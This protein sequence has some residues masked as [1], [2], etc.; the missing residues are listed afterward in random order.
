[1]LKSLALST[2]AVAVLLPRTMV[3][4]QSCEVHTLPHDTIWGST[5]AGGAMH[6]DGD[7][8]SAG[9]TLDGLGDV[10]VWKVSKEGDLIW[11]KRFAALNKNVHLY[12]YEVAISANG[13]IIVMGDRQDNTP[14]DY[15]RNQ[16]AFVLSSTGEILWARIYMLSDQ[17][18]DQ[19]SFD[20]GHDINPTSTGWLLTLSKSDGIHAIDL[21][22]NGA[23]LSRTEYRPSADP[24]DCASG[25]VLVEQN[26][27]R[28]LTGS[29]QGKPFVMRIAS[30]GQVEW[31]FL[32]HFGEGHPVAVTKASNG[33]YLIAG[34]KRGSLYAEPDYDPFAMRISV[35]G[36]FQWAYDYNVATTASNIA[37]LPNGDIVMSC[38]RQLRAI[39]MSAAGTPISCISSTLPS[40]GGDLLGVSGDS[41]LFGN[42]LFE[43]FVTPGTPQV[44]IADSFNALTCGGLT[45]SALP[46]W[47][48]Y[49]TST[50]T[51]TLFIGTDSTRTW[52][53]ALGAPVEMDALD[54]EVY[55]SS[56]PARPGFEVGLFGTIRNGMMLPSGPIEVTMAL[57][58]VLSFVQAT[59]TPTSVVGNSVTWNLPPLYGM[60]SAH[61]VYVQAEVP[62]DVTLLGSELSN[63]LN[64]IQDS[65]EHSL[66]NNTV[67]F[68][69]IVTGSY[70]PNDKL[71]FPKD[72]YHIT[73]DSILDYT[74]RFQN[75]GT[76]TAFNI[77]VIDTLPPDVDVLTFEAGA[78]SHPY[79]YTL[80]G[81]GLLK[82]T[83]NNILLPDSNTNEPLSHGLVNFRIKP[84]QPIYLGQTISNEADIYFDFNPPVRT[85][86]AAVVVTDFMAVKPTAPTNELKLYPVPV[87]DVLTVEVPK[88]FLP[89]NAL[90]TANDGRTVWNSGVMNTK[91][92]L[93]IPVQKLAIG[94]YTLTLLSVHGERSQARFVKE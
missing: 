67:T 5:L 40:G 23:I 25:A 10:V 81:E 56:G 63:V 43:E 53:M 15:Q 14:F 85:P 61:G 9:L 74:I 66:A 31:A 72:F 92:R 41:L 44:T 42:Y 21:D 62:Q 60:Q 84:I 73:N 8:V 57:D 29:A 22:N 59:P 91:E 69:R 17:L 46:P 64:T 94:A 76:D 30:G 2:I 77:V 58:P 55:A 37:E 19:L 80:T 54:L 88:G 35:T 12:P 48:N 93:S 87:R 68:T 71:V 47:T 38:K 70:D 86:P 16:F 49:P 39:Q 90:I 65:I 3:N 6:P 7:I 89:R 11:S 50:V 83:F 1:M 75:T 20:F 27:D 79:T 36:A 33:D 18:N 82:F 26:G 28:I 45:S 13:E 32:Y 51:D 78:A 24:Y 4:A 52:T 34:A